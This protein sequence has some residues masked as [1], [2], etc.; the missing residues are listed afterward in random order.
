MIKVNYVVKFLC[1]LHSKLGFSHWR[2]CGY[3]IESINVCS[4]YL[5]KHGYGKHFR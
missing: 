2:V 1:N 5:L 3:I 4:L